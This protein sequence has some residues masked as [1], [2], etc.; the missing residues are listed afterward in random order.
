MIPQL[1]S[2]A[3]AEEIMR[4]QILHVDFLGILPSFPFSPGESEPLPRPPLRLHHSS[5]HALKSRLRPS[6]ALPSP[7]PPAIITWVYLTPVETYHSRVLVLQLT[8]IRRAK[9]ARDLLVKV[10]S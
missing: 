3:T 2:D 4:Y 1:S 5:R 10:L 7:S 9:E 8:A 6:Q